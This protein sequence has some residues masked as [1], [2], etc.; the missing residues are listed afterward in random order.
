M[1]VWYDPPEGVL[2]KLAPMFGKKVKLKVVGYAEDD[3][4]QAVVIQTRLPI[5]GQH[6]HITVSVASGTKAA[7][8]NTLL[9][10]G[11]KKVVGPT[12]DAVLTV[13]R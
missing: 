3:K 6:P 13:Q 4:G 10:R 12:L 2:G 7:Y 9:A 5:K 1:T 11:F 8:S